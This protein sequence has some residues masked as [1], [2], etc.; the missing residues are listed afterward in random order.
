LCVDGTVQGTR[1]KEGLF[2]NFMSCMLLTPHA[3]SK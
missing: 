1:R 2:A 3:V